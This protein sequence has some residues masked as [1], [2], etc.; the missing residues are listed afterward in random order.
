MS[1]TILRLLLL[2]VVSGT[3][4]FA[5]DTIYT[6]KVDVPI[7]T[8]DVSVRDSSAKPVNNLSRSDFEVYEDGVRQEISFFSPVATPYNVFLLF[9]RSGSTQHK[10]PFMQRAVAGFIASLR[11]QDRIAIGSFDFEFQLHTEWTGDRNKALLALPDLIHPKAAGGTDFYGALERTLR[12]GF[13][14]ATGRRAVVVLTDGRDTSLYRTLVQKNRLLEPSEDRGF[15]KV[16]KAGREQRIPLYF[17]AINTDMNLEPNDLGS[18]EYRNLHIL[19]PRSGMADRYL[20]RVRDRMEQLAEVSGGRVLF[21]NRIEDIIPLYQQIGQEL[22][23]SYSLG[24]VSSNS[25]AN[26]AFRGIE[27]RAR[28]NQLNV[29]QSRSG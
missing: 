29:T 15:Q 3:R 18:D 23:V 26:G 17:V 21:P 19:F 10:W 22:G 25:V 2:G 27:V 6:L 9:D 16:L 5:Q 24:Y 4:I 7:V 11:Q 14:N 8:V 1:R 28:V 20:A 13:Q 12:R